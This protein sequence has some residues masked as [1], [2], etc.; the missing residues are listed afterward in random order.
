M[1]NKPGYKTT[2]FWMSLFSTVLPAIAAGAGVIP[3]ES[4]AVI[5]GVVTSMYTASRAFLKARNKPRETI[6][7]SDRGA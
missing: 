7:R 3:A 1:E 5:G 4:A 2:E 6:R